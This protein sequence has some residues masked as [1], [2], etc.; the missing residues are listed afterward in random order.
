[1]ELMMSDEKIDLR[2]REGRAMKEQGLGL[3]SPES[4]GPEGRRISR[5]NRKPFGSQTQKL[6]FKKREGYHHHWFNETPGRI[7]AAKEAGYSHVVDETT[8]KPIQMVVGVT[9]QGGPLSGFLM[10]VPEEWFNDDM[11]AQQ[12]AVDDKEDTIRRGQV[13]A[14]DPRDR[15]D[16]FRNTAQGRKIDMRHTM[17]RRNSTS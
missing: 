14:T 10:E 6:A 9:A 17:A 11:A 2:T 3:A 5:E 8:G 16:R 1:V 15:D 13:N 4:D 12:Q 7:N